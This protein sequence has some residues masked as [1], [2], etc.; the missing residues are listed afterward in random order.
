M[1]NK[2]DSLFERIKKV[3]NWPVHAIGIGFSIAM[4]IAIVHSANSQAADAPVPPTAQER[5]IVIPLSVLN[6]LKEKLQDLRDAA[7]KA[8]RN[9]RE[10]RDNY[11]DA[12]RCIKEHVKEMRPVLSCFKSCGKLGNMCDADDHEF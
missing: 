6:D 11:N 4:I 10:W 9:E 7:I 5:T 2:S 12:K 1:A 3:D 8:Q